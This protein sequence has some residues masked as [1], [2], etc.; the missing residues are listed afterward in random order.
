[1][2]LGPPKQRA[3]LAVLL[4]NAGRVVSSATASPTRCGARST[5]RTW[6]RA[7]RPTSPTSAGCCATTSGPPRRSSAGPGLPARL[8]AAAELD[9]ETFTASCEAARQALDASD[10]RGGGRGGRDRAS[11]SGEDRSWPSTR[12]RNGWS[13]RR[14]RLRRTAHV[15]RAGPGDWPARRRPAG[16]ALDG[17]GTG[18][19]RQPL[20]ERGLLAAAAHA[21]PR[22]TAAEALDVYREHIARLDDELGLDSGPALRDLQGAILR[23]DPELAIL[24]GR[25][26]ART[27]PTRNATGSRAGP[28]AGGRAMRPAAGQPGVVE[29]RRTESVPSPPAERRRDRPGRSRSG[30]DAAVTTLQETRVYGEQRWVIFTGEAGIGKSRLAAED[31][32]PVGGAEGGR[33]LTSA[34][35]DDDG[36]P[37]LVADPGPPAWARRRPGRGADPAGRGRRGRGRLRRLRPGDRGV[38]AA[39]RHEPLLLLDRGRALGRCGLAAVPHPPRWSPGQQVPL[40]LV[41]TARDGTGRADLGRLLAAMARRPGTRRLSVPPLNRG[42]GGR[43]R[44][45]RERRAALRRPSWINWPAG[46]AATPSSSASTPTCRRRSGAAGRSRPP[47]ARCWAPASP[48]STPRSSTS[49][50]PPR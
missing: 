49:S 25:R 45:A 14:P 40:A 13:A 41:L 33:V 28:E 36:I 15:D 17:P 50:G 27:P 32:R 35:P 10:W 30:L 48:C 11:T 16:R 18:R 12:T 39:A 19:R 21:V 26:P 29:P 24:A 22:R 37:L 43:A 5:R 46:P 3:V 6:R 23:Q 42:R 31:G 7:S 44:R 8:S 4:L 34:C 9:V 38:S 1:M 47:S 2:E 20:S